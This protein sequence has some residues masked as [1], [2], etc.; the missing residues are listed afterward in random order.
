MSR[1]GATIRRLADSDFL[2]IFPLMRIYLAG[3]D[4]FLPAPERRRAALTAVC[5]RHGHEGVWPLDPPPLAPDEVASLP[6]ARRIALGNE[7]HIRSCAALVANLTPF[8]GP[9]ADPGT[10]FEIGFAR[11]LGLKLAG[12]TNDARCLATRTR[13][14]LG[15]EGKHDREGLRVEDPFR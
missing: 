10:A 11:M 2:G 8:R 4:V 14:W 13:A 3:P 5:A 1:A 12:W 7:A 9:N 6:E 15:V